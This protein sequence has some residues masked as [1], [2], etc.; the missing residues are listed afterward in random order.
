MES[1][2]GTAFL[3]QT[4]IQTLVM[5]APDDREIPFA[6][7]EALASAGSHAHLMAIPGFGHRRIL[8]APKV[9]RAAARFIRTGE[10]GPDAAAANL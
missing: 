9:H 2:S 8:M 5:H 4:Q 1:F 7:A 6:D 10:V 3:K